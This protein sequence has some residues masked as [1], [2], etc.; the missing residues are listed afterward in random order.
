MGNYISGSKI[1]YEQ[2]FFLPYNA[3]FFL[4]ARNDQIAFC[5]PYNLSM[6]VLYSKRLHI[7]TF[8]APSPQI[9]SI[10]YVSKTIYLMHIIKC[11]L[12]I[13]QNL[14]DGL[15]MMPADRLVWNLIYI[16]KKNIKTCLCKDID[17]ESNFLLE[18]GNC[19]SVMS[20]DNLMIYYDKRNLMITAYHLCIW[21]CAVFSEF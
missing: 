11:R 19:I 10:P 5:F 12:A 15:T 18:L 7:R 13:F 8:T 6:F 1:A 4:E 16:K 21:M 2:L 3:L 20:K 9:R 14:T 17:P